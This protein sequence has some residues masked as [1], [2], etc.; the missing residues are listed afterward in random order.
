ML[1]KASCCYCYTWVLLGGKVQGILPTLFE[2][3]QCKKLVMQFCLGCLFSSYRSWCLRAGL[4]CWMLIRVL[5]FVFFLGGFHFFYK[6]RGKGRERD[7]WGKFCIVW[8]RI[9]GNV[10][11]STFSSLSPLSFVLARGMV[12]DLANR[13]GHTAHYSNFRNWRDSTP[14][15]KNNFVIEELLDSQSDI[16]WRHFFE[17]WLSQEWTV[18]QQAYYQSTKYLRTG[19]RWMVALI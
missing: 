13:S 3:F 18:A 2:K 4:S 15:K 16:G 17:G 9:I 10:S 6:V 1:S 19:R 8:R 11:S 7:L 12:Q 14:V 5:F